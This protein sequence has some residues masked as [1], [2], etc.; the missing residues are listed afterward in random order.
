MGI[1]QYD[2]KQQRFFQEHLFELVRL[3]PL[4]MLESG[5]LFLWHEFP[6]SVRKESAKSLLYVLQEESLPTP[7]FDRS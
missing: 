3:H 6:G 5:Y 1:H 7:L 2:E 4:S